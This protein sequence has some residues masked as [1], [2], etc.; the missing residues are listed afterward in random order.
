MTRH[1]QG[2]NIKRSVRIYV[3]NAGEVCFLKKIEHVSL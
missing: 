1:N 3:C 2:M